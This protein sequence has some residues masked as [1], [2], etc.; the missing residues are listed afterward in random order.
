[1]SELRA[2]LEALEVAKALAAASD[3]RA[4]AALTA[5]REA[6]NSVTDLRAQLQTAQAYFPIGK[7]PKQSVSV[8]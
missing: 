4:E 7:A 6:E 5:T 8:S 3:T 1:M 2:A